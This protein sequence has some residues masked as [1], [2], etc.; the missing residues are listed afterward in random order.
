[1]TVP[2]YSCAING[3][4]ISWRIL[5]PRRLLRQRWPCTGR[6][7]VAVSSERTGKPMTAHWGVED[8]AALQG[9][10]AEKRQRFREVA[11]MLR[12]RI[13]RFISLPLATLDR[14]TLQA[15]LK[16]L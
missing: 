10:D 1:M 14:M 9:T 15:A 6:R 5:K 8:P 11:L 16:D 12:Q 7:V 13:E 2:S 3:F 4:P